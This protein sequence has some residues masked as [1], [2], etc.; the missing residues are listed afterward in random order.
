MALNSLTDKLSGD[1]DYVV[2]RRQ[3]NWDYL[4]RAH[5]GEVHWLNV[6]HLSKS[7]INK[8]IPTEKLVKRIRRWFLLGLSLG[9]LL[10]LSEGATLVCALTQL[11]EEYEHFIGAKKDMASSDTEAHDPSSS[12][13]SLLPSSS[14]DIGQGHILVYL[15]S[16]HGY[17]QAQVIGALAAQS[18]AAAAA[19]APTT[20][21]E[22]IKPTLKKVGKEVVYEYLQTHATCLV[23]YASEAEIGLEG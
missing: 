10:E 2:T 1:I 5:Q 18:Q 14:R 17:A 7:V 21:Q 13:S 15:A 19:A 16:A 12:S 4:K 3:Q 6:L 8:S 9:R 11:I 23:S 22:H 20:T